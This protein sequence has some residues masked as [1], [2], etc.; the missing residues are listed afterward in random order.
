MPRQTSKQ[1]QTYHWLKGYCKPT[2]FPAS[3]N[4]TPE[5][6]RKSQ[7][8]SGLNQD[9]RT[10]SFKIDGMRVLRTVFE[11]GRRGRKRSEQRQKEKKNVVVNSNTTSSSSEPPEATRSP[12]SGAG[13]RSVQ[14]T[15]IKAPESPPQRRPRDAEPGE[16]QLDPLAFTCG[17]G[18]DLTVRSALFLHFR[19]YENSLLK[20]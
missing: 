8:E 4:Q 3:A 9:W 5:T 15:L 10:E 11:N 12:T 7:I 18:A 20:W 1:V 17:S 2:S 6:A 13:E 19:R 14:A 16:T